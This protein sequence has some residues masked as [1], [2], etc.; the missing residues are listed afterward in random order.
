MKLSIKKFLLMLAMALVAVIAFNYK[1]VGYGIGQA[2]GQLKVLWHARPIAEV[3]NDQNFPDSLKSTLKMVEKIK[4]YAVDSLHLK[5]NN[6]YTKVFDQQGKEILWVVTACDPY[7]FEPVMYSFPIIGSFTYKGFFDYNKAVDL[8]KTQKNKGHDVH[9]RSVSGWSTLGWFN[10]PI[11]SNMLNSGPGELANT[12]IHELTHGTIFIPDSMTFNE[13]L[14][15]FIGNRGALEYLKTEFGVAS[16]E[17]QKYKSRKSD[18]RKFTSHIVAGAK[19][20]ERLYKVVENEPDSIKLIEKTMFIEKIANELDTISFSNAAFYHGYFDKYKPNNAYFISFLN[21][22][23]RQDDFNILFEDSLNS[24]LS[25][26]IN[27][28]KANYE[29]D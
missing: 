12:I 20:L 8:A 22:R 19:E 9:L 18:S 23:E 1:L 24:D 6:N 2:R 21:Y 3:L 29:K 5:P 26:F 11:L 15:T 28:W 10:D 7:K 17:Y 13:N 4:A 16:D 14:A 25:L 27:Y